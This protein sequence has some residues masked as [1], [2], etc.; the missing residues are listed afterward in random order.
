MKLGHLSEQLPTRA[1]AD[2]ALQ[3]QEFLGAAFGKPLRLTLTHN[4][5]TMLSYRETDGVIGLR[6]HVMFAQAEGRIWDA[7]A[8][9]LVDGHRAA[10]RLIDAYIDVWLETHPPPAEAGRRRAMPLRP[11]GAYHDL[12]AILAEQNRLYFHDACRAAI[13]WGAAHARSARRSIQLGCFVQA[14]CLIRMHPCLDQAFVP[15]FYVAWVVFHEML[16]EVFGT[17]HGTGRRV[18]HPP[19]FVAIETTYPDYP[20]CKAWETLNL[21]RL[22]R[23]RPNRT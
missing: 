9:Y 22:L 18:V 1:V 14:D 12:G 17:E 15:R 19:A 5:S 20:R 23:F 16:H 6:L 21:P 8:L 11:V 10:G 4:R 2:A 7:L 3:L 13:T